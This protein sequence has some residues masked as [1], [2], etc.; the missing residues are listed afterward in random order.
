M[1]E[2]RPEPMASPVPD[3]GSGGAGEAPALEQG[4]NTNV[5]VRRDPTGDAPVS[6]SR[7]CRGLY[8]SSNSFLTVGHI[9]PCLMVRSPAKAKGRSQGAAPNL[10]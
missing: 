9:L 8:S 1:R 3:F 6:F 4:G 10:S 2:V 5:V 7:Q